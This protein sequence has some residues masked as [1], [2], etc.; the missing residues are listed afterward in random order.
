MSCAVR[1]AVVRLHVPTS[2]AS[3]SIRIRVAASSDKFCSNYCAN[4]QKGLEKVIRQ[5]TQ[6]LDLIGGR[7]LEL[8]SRGHRGQP[9]QCPV[10]VLTKF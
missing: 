2:F 10:Y 1:F 3:F 4:G 9:E 7:G 8:G 5:G 6:V